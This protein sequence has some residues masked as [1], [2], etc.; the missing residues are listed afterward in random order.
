MLLGVVY[1]E[2]LLYAFT[3]LVSVHSAHRPA[4]KL[5]LHT[6]VAPAC[7]AHQRCAVLQQ[8]DSSGRKHVPCIK[9]VV[10][11]VAINPN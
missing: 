5:S 11:Y 6:K 10:T 2:A 9:L 3:P 1:Q 8:Q 4:I 7:S